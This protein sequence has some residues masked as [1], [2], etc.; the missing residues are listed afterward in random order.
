MVSIFKQIRF[1]CQSFSNF[2]NAITLSGLLGDTVAVDV[3]D[4][5]NTM[6]ETDCE[7]TKSVRR[8]RTPLLEVKKIFMLE[9]TKV[10]NRGKKYT[11]S[12]S[13]P[14][15]TFTF[16]CSFRDFYTEQSVDCGLQYSSVATFLF[17]S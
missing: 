13:G 10:A 4:T 14:N 8:W 11:P 16:Q 9:V 1:R 6:M 5:A 7:V 17:N 15:I 3:E 12:F 2:F